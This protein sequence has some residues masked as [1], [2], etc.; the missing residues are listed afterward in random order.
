MRVGAEAQKGIHLLGF[1][2]GDDNQAH[3]GT[4]ML[5]MR[6]TKGVPLFFLLRFLSRFLFT[7]RK[8]ATLQLGALRYT[9]VLLK[10]GDIPISLV[11]PQAFLYSDAHFFRMTKHV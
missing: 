1:R 8:C 3:I 6:H 4:P 2:R 5:T 10:C 7:F 11:C 9:E